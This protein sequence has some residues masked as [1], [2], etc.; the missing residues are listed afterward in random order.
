MRKIM[1]ILPPVALVLCLVLVLIMTGVWQIPSLS[2]GPTA[3][4]STGTGNTVPSTSTPEETTGGE[5]VRQNMIS[6]ALPE[7]TNTVVSEDGTVLFRH[8]FQDISLISPNPRVNETVTLD[9]LQRM[10]INASTVVMLEDMTQYYTPGTE[11]NTLYYEFIYSP[12]R[13]DNA[14]LSLKG[15]ESVY[16]GSGQA[17]NSIICV[18]YYLPTGQV[19]TLGETLSEESGSQDALLQ[20][21][22]RV[23]AHNATQWELFED[24]SE[25]VIRYFPSYL[26]QENNWFFSPEGLNICFAPY[27]IAP[28]TSGTVVAT[29]PYE[30]LTGILRS[31]LLPAEYT[32]V[33]GSVRVENLATAPLDRYTYFAECILAAEGENHLISTNTIVYDVRLDLGFLESNGNF[34][35][36]A[37]VFAANSLCSDQ[38]IRLCWTPDSQQLLLRGTIDGTVKSFLLSVNTDGTV[39]LSPL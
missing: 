35:S 8:T 14:I 33:G 11:W 20:A 23:L 6:I 22:L 17:N 1:Y 15:A 28:Q 26:Q 3:S 5:Y 32:P 25:P 21:L 10:D 36:T 31:D 16:T 34:I 39:S 2:P 19:M 30:E 9:L 38:A 24:Y 13:I 29:I 37:T 12:T 7:M 4:Q 18:N 27:E